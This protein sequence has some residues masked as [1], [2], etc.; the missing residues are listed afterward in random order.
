MFSRYRTTLALQSKSRSLKG[1]QK[2]FII[3]AVERG[4]LQLSGFMTLIVF[5]MMRRIYDE[6]KETDALLLRLSSCA[7]IVSKERL[8]P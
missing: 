5:P 6:E 1:L 4:F 7:H 3:L 2:L 8:E